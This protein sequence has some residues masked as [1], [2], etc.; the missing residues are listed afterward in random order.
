MTSPDQNNL[1][2]SDRQKVL[3]GRVHEAIAEIDRLAKGGT[4]VPIDEYIDRASLDGL[5]D[6]LGLDPD[7]WETEDLERIF[8]IREG[9]H[10]LRRRLREVGD[11]AEHSVDQLLSAVDR[12]YADLDQAIRESNQAAIQKAQDT[13][14]ELERSP[15]VPTSHVAESANAVRAQAAEMLTR[16][17]HT[18]RQINTTIINVVNNNKSTQVEVSLIKSLQVNVQRLS[19]SAFAIKLSLEAKVIFQGIIKFLSVGADK[20]VNELRTILK[21]LKS[22][23]AKATEFLA[24]L[25][26]LIEEGGRFARLVGDFL[27][28]VFGDEEEFSGSTVEF[29]LQS[30]LKGSASFGA[31]QLNSQNVTLVGKS[32][33]VIGLDART[34]RLISQLQIGRAT[35]NSVCS[36]DADYMCLGTEEGLRVAKAVGQQRDADYEASYRENV[37]SVVRPRWGI[38]TGAR[39]GTLRLWTL[40]GNLSQLSSIKVGRS[41][42][43][44]LVADDSVVVAS[45][46]S[47]LFVGLKENSLEVIKDAGSFGFKITDL[48]FMNPDSL[49]VCGFGNLAHFNITKGSYARLL[50]MSSGTSYTA[51]QRLTDTILLVGTEDDR[52]LALDINSGA[53]IGEI[54]VE[55]PVKGMIVLGNHVL[56]YGGS[57]NSR[58][59]RAIAY[60]TYKV[61][62][63]AVEF[64]QND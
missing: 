5:C 14:R 38:V 52:L 30:A 44:L 40:A 49:M 17:H 53:E 33:Q 46:E 11:E 31:T 3:I 36:Y 35:I 57:R 21:S 60:L 10:S 63:E 29:K 26:K 64:A 20:V 43:K 12:L 41:V 54:D 22:A 15:Q 39:E 61:N 2:P 56:A 51:V 48:N 45:N 28:R 9:L 6:S 55:F 62:K 24:D 23:Y 18:A 4:N 16:T 50:T 13:I 1:S 59:A 8:L 42:Q 58:G 25:A 47:V 7:A 37:V 19:A 32:G 27:E 34:G